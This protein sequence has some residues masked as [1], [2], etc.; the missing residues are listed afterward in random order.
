[1]EERKKHD[2]VIVPII[3]PYRQSR[4]EA[5]KSLIPD[6]YEIYFSASLD[7]VKQ[8]DVKGLYAESANGSINNLIGVSST[9]PYQ[10]P[11][12]PDFI[13]NTEKE[14]IQQSVENLFCF[15]MICLKV[16]HAKQ[17]KKR[18]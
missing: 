13:I 7:C 8:R 11:E 2:V 4:R 1:S 15:T 6:F 9:N 3:S 5:R 10:P 14:S 16:N 18:E 12:S 17:M